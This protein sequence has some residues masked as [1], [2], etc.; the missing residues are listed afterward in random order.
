MIRKLKDELDRL[1]SGSRPLTQPD[2]QIFPPLDTRLFI[3]QLNLDERALHDGESNIPQTDSRQLC[4]IEIEIKNRIEEAHVDYAN[5]YH[6]H[7]SQYQERYS[8]CTKLWKMDLV[9]NEERQLVDDV[10]A[11]ANNRAGPVFAR[12]E[13]LLGTAEQLMRFREKNQ[14]LDRLPRMTDVYRL[15]LIVTISLVI[16]F[17]T[18]VYL[19]RE[20][21]DSLL[22]VAVLILLFCVLN[23]IFPILVFS[24]LV[25]SMFSIRKILKIFGLF[26]LTMVASFGVFLNL[27][28]GHFRLVTMDFASRSA[29][30]LQSGDIQLF[31]QE[32]SQQQQLARLAW[33]SLLENGIYIEDTWAWLLI[34]LNLIIYFYSLYE[35]IIKDDPYPG[36]GEVT[37]AFED[38]HEDY[39]AEIEYA[40]QELSFLREDA[41][42]AVEDLK[43]KLY[44]T[45]NTAPQLIVNSENL[46]EKYKQRALGLNSLYAE[47]VMRYREKNIAARSDEAPQYFNDPLPKEFPL[48]DKSDI[49][50]VE[51]SAQ[52]LVQRLDNFSTRIN[53]EFSIIQDK[54]VGS[55]EVLKDNYPLRVR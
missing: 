25:K 11:E 52:L 41:I 35:G 13:K 47:L 54:I 53:K 4:N 48:L 55:D 39:N 28:M 33:Q 14:L 2:G 6:D 26:A 29:I 51:P 8:D 31:L 5:A 34:P 30:S 46:Y 19:T 45:F 44:T 23:T 37:E 3:K 7:F 22:T 42:D 21:S 20:A 49:K 16:E 1:I 43:D 10:I 36:Y 12:K 15:L 40:Q 32:F 18:A 27:L 50:K 24:K 38:A 9:E 17:V